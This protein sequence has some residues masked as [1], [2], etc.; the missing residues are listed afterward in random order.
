MKK[1]MLHRLGI[2]A[3]ALF[4]GLA[5]AALT[6]GTVSA[7]GSRD[8]CEGASPTVGYRPYTERNSAETAGE[9]RDQVIM[10]YMNKGETVCF[11]TS[12]SNAKLGFTNAKMGTKLTD[13]QLA[14]LN[15]NDIL[16]MTPDWDSSKNPHAYP[17]LNGTQDASILLYNVA[18]TPADT[19]Q[20]YIADYARESGGPNTGTA[21]SGYTPFRYTAAKSGTYSF[22]FF[23]A[24]NDKGNPGMCRVTAA[25]NQKGNCVAAWDATV[26]DTDN[27]PVTGRVYTD[28]LF[29]NMG[30]NGSGTES[31]L[32]SKVYAVTSDGYQYLV[33]FNGMDPY[34]FVFFANNRGLLDSSETDSIHSLYHSVK[35][36]NNYLSDLTNHDIILNNLPYSDSDQT[37]HLFFNKPDSTALTALGIPVDPST[38]GSVSSFKFT[39]TGDGTGYVG[40]GGTFSFTVDTKTVTATSY[41]ITLDFTSVKGGKVILSNS[42]KNGTNSVY[43]DGKDANGNVV[44]AGTYQVAAADVRLKGGEVHFPLLDV[45]TI[46]NGIRIARINGSGATAASPDYTVHYNNSGASN[47]GNADAPWSV[48]TN[49]DVADKA[50]ASEGVSS[51]EG[52]MKYGKLAGDQTA[53]D[54]WANYSSNGMTSPYSFTLTATSF[55]V[56]KTWVREV[57]TA[58]GKNVT[59]TA[60]PTT[61]TMTLKDKEGNVVTADAAGMA[62]LNPVT[63]DTSSKNAYTWSALDPSRTYSVTEKAVTGYSTVYGDVS[64]TAKDGYAETVTN[65][66]APAS[67]TLYKVWDHGT[68]DSSLWPAGVSITLTGT[69]SAKEEKYSNTLTLTSAKDAVSDTEWKRTV[70]GLD[71]N[72]T[73]AAAE[74]AVS[75]YTSEVFPA[76]GS[77]KDGFGIYI[78]NVHDTSDNIAL[79]VFKYWQDTDSSQRPASIKMTLKDGSGNTVTSDADGRAITNPVT[80][81]ASGNWMYLWTNMSSTE[82]YTLTEDAVPGYTASP[83]SLVVLKH[84]GYIGYDNKE[85]TNSFTVTKN[86]VHG[87]NSVISQQPS[88]VKVH[89]LESTDSGKTY[90][91][92]GRTAELNAAGS[93]KYTWTD[94]SSAASDGTKILYR[95]DEEEVANYRTDSGT[96]TQGSDGNWTQTIANTYRYTKVSVSKDWDYGD[97]A[98]A[99]RP[100]S[101]SVVLKKNGSAIKSCTLNAGNDW[102]YTFDDLDIYD[103]DGRAAA[104]TVE[105]DSIENYTAE[106]GTLSGS[107]QTGYTASFKNTC[108]RGKS[109]QTTLRVTKVWNHGDQT[110]DAYPASAA[111]ILYQNGT[112]TDKTAELNEANGWT[113]TFTGLAAGN[114]YTVA[115]TAVADYT[116]SYSEDSGS[117]EAG[118]QITVTNTY[119]P[120]TSFTVTKTWEHGTQASSSWPSEITVHLYQEGTDTGLTVRLNA[121][122]GWTA[123]FTNLKKYKSAGTRYEYRVY[124]DSVAGYRLTSSVTNFSREGIWTAALTNTYKAG[125]GGTDANSAST[126]KTSGSSSAS[127]SSTSAG[128]TSKTAASDVATGDTAPGFLLYAV[129]MLF[130]AAAVGG[131]CRYDLRK[132]TKD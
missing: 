77:A 101:V 100:K 88:S 106:G 105:E 44:P 119:D 61:V 91:D 41:Q 3:A 121:D 131:L 24:N 122:N 70:Y 35:S 130:A 12:V 16:I 56:T 63:F 38:K 36:L 89:L 14:S 112:A 51:S 40:R 110:A 108:I 6:A 52:T 55:T 87:T 60:G 66:Y 99:D 118:H 1:V 109:S 86:W 65:T 37:Y 5:A 83:E 85:L 47:A 97:Q 78:A 33:D 25:W 26:F 69:N 113:Y 50:D 4:A 74:T 123:Q 53:L 95:A 30:H 29:L 13:A 104:Y 84:F 73:Y 49:W 75:G 57:R 27:K 103:A 92:T 125:S 107:A 126:G 22:K 39:G 58:D 127:A 2:F 42:L 17:Y 117:D 116:V 7:E 96:P 34:G 90:L 15:D 82:K 80:L 79:E 21:T 59:D 72:L 111:V 19:T 62:I 20:G 48:G 124:E 132:K 128:G 45:E 64:G 120:K 93:W 67:L 68:Q 46:P 10:V 129:M 54:I 114:A 11:G 94:L 32:M 98:E 43:W 81:T 102:I 23:S 9:V 8:L 71:P 115:E 76:G 31:V 28:T 18:D